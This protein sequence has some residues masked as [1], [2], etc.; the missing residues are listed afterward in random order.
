MA[1]NAVVVSLSFVGCEDSVDSWGSLNSMNAL[2]SFR[3][4]KLLEVLI[5]G[6][7][8]DLGGSLQKVFGKGWGSK[9]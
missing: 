1:I 4:S 6:V 3:S 5:Q 9:L 7:A 8:G 2:H